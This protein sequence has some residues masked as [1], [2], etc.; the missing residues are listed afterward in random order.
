MLARFTHTLNRFVHETDGAYLI[1][2]AITMPVLILLSLGLLEFSLVSFEFQKA[3]EA[4]RRA[5]RFLIIGNDIPNTANLL[6]V[7]SAVMIT[8]T[9]TGGEVSCDNASPTGTQS[10]GTYPTAN[11]NFQAMFDQMVAIKTDLK[12]EHVVVTYEST[13]VG[14]VDNAGGVIPMVTVTITGLEHTF[15]TGEVLGFKTMPFPD[16]KTSIL[17]S[18]RM[19]NSS[20]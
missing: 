19:V 3:S 14:D 20:T 12:E 10:G 8:C 2:F 11:E 15:V 7:E 5:A 16:F 4:T 9:S 17:G 1:E 6:D 18:G 13:K